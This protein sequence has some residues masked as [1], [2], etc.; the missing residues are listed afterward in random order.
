MHPKHVVKMIL[1]FTLVLLAAFL[2]RKEGD[3]V[4]AQCQPYRCVDG[5]EIPSCAEDGHVINYFAPPCMTHGGE[6]QE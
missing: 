5:T 6:V 4:S 1:A 2:L 3:P